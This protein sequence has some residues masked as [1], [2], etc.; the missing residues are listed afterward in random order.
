M[1]ALFFALG[2]VHLT[3]AP[4]GRVWF[5]GQLI[6][7]GC[8]ALAYWSVLRYDGWKA[9]LLAGLGAQHVSTRILMLLTL[10]S[11]IGYLVGAVFLIVN[12]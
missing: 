8:V 2:T 12:I 10:I 5:T 6:G 4:L 7:L 1:L 3:L 11:V 9:F